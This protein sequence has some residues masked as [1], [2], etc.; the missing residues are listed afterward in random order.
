M[1]HQQHHH[2]HLAAGRKV[3]NKLSKSAST[4]SMNLFDVAGGG[5]DGYMSS[6]AAAAM[7]RLKGYQFFQVRSL[8][9]LK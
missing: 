4:A 7:S 1:H 3:K 5:M 6:G 8:M 2:H 9:F